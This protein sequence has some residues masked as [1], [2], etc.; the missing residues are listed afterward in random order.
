MGRIEG[1]S[2][3]NDNDIMSPTRRSKCYSLCAKIVYSSYIYDIFT[4]QSDQTAI[5]V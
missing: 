3:T 2:M 5:Y 1:L 4:H